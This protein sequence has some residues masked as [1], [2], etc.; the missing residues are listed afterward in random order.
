MGE[1]DHVTGNAYTDGGCYDD[2]ASVQI[3]NTLGML[4]NNLSSAILSACGAADPRTDNLGC[5]LTN[6]NNGRPITIPAEL[7]RTFLR[8]TVKPTLPRPSNVVSCPCRKLVA[9]SVTLWV[10]TQSKAYP[11][12]PCG[13]GFP[14]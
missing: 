5:P 7:R 1:R 13:L 10:S 12:S 6:G 14:P 4:S 3:Q 9:T 2:L 8:R 11:L